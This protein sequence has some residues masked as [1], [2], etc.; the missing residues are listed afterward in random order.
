MVKKIVI[1]L[2]FVVLFVLQ[3]PLFMLYHLDFYSE[4]PMIEWL[5]VMWHGLPL[6]LSC[7]GYVMALPFLIQL[8]YIWRPGKWHDKVMRTYLSIVAIILLVIFLVDLV[9]YS[10]WGFKLDST[11]IFYIV[12]GPEEALLSAPNWA[13]F[14]APVLVA[15]V[16]WLSHKCFSKV[17]PLNCRKPE[18][19]VIANRGLATVVQILLCGI[20]FIFIRGDLSSSTI[21]MGRV[22]YSSEMRLNHAATN[23]AFSFFS[24]LHKKDFSEQY[25]FMSDE[26]ANEAMIELFVNS[27]INALNDSIEVD[28]NLLNTNRP[29][30]LLILFESFSGGAVEALNPGIDS[31]VMPNI[32]RMYREGIGFTNIY[33]NSF[34][35]D[36]GVASVLASYPGQPTNSIITDQKK[37]NNLEYISKRLGENGYQNQF[38]HGGDI[39]FNNLQGFLRAGDITDFVSQEDFAKSDNMSKWGVPD[40][41]MFN[42]IYDQ[43]SDYPQ[44]NDPY[45]KVFLTLSSHEPFDV[46]YHHLDNEYAN[47]AAYTDSCFGSFIDRLKASPQWDNLLI[48]GVADHSYANYPVGVENHEIMRYHIPMF[49]TGGAIKGPR[50]IDTYGSQTD[51]AATLLSQMDIEH[52]DFNF[53]KDLMYNAIP[54]FAF[55]AFSDGFGF[56]TDSCKYIQDN[57]HDGFPLSGSN[58]PSGNAERWGKAY[59]QML[60][61]DL[62]QR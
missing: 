58:D 43:I 57:K 47:S 29:N 49:W 21:D 54:H 12:N 16:W 8:L 22:Y 32:N 60:Y 45:F 51:I 26:E 39:T 31:N 10:Y 50:L 20:L 6:D 19:L 44:E 56:L 4:Y 59:L 1:Y 36:R 41:I 15:F 28:T 2:V 3:K 7:A 9:L 11:P 46:P 55:Y 38:I 5:R 52:E 61:D 48:I 18:Y 13:Y 24:T 17:Y 33:A 40:H 35:T 37:C 14:V 53:S 25:R 27:H 34:R 62:S 23:P 42:Y 30:I